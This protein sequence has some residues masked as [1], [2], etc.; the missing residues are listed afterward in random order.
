MTTPSLFV[1]AEWLAEHI[2]DENVQVLD[3]RMLPPGQELTRDVTAEYQ[4]AH[5]PGAPFFNIEALSD[6]SSALPHMLPRAEAF[7]VAMRELGVSADTHLVVYDEGNLFSAPRA[8][9]MLNYFGA[10]QVS[11]L[12]GGLAG[13]QKANLPLESGE[14]D[15]P[16]GDFQA[17][18]TDGERV[19]RVTD[20]LLVSHEGGAQIIDARAANRFHGEVDEPRP[21]LHRGRIPGSLNVPWNSLVTEGQLKPASELRAIFSQQGVDLA[22][23]VIASCGSGV[24]AVVVILALTS[25]GAKDVTLYDGSW[26]EWGS[27]NDLPIVN[28]AL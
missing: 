22:Q 18:V 28:D 11:I 5:L 26:G 19:K 8:W 10:E 3:A 14:V 27:R 6:H 25:L 24:T 2:A 21:G 23:P 7:A 12:A 4:T 20:V 9:W 13:W 16:E 17:N 1:T 15:L